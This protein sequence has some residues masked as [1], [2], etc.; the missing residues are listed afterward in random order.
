MLLPLLVDT[1][2]ERGVSLYSLAANWSGIR[3]DDLQLQ[4]GYD[5]TKA[6]AQSKL[7]CLTFGL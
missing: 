2:R 1:T 3:F 6:N 4:T 5:A 7:A